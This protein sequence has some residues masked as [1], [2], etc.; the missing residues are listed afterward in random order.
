MHEPFWSRVCIAG[1]S[2]KRF[3]DLGGK[4]GHGKIG[5]PNDSRFF[6]EDDECDLLDFGDV[7]R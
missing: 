2:K 4:K 1:E 3:Q 5:N 7:I 6:R